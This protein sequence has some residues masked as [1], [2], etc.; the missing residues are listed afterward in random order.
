VIIDE[1][2]KFSVLFVAILS[3]VWGVYWSIVKQ[4]NGDDGAL[5]AKIDDQVEKRKT[6][7]EALRTN[8]DTRFAT[9]SQRDAELSER[10]AT[11]K[12][13]AFKELGAYV[14][15]AEFDKRMERLESGQYIQNAKLDTILERITRR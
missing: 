7:L 1:I 11:M 9:C 4:M 10:I 8:Y 13:E 3:L 5:N 15:R 14:T 6:T 2:I 12:L